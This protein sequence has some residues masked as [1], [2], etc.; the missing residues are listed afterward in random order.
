MSSLAE[1][2]SQQLAKQLEAE[3]LAAVAEMEQ[4]E[5]LEALHAAGIDPFADDAPTEAAETDDERAA[6]EADEAAAVRAAAEAEAALGIASGGPAATDHGESGH[7][8]HRERG[9]L[10]ALG[11][12]WKMSSSRSAATHSSAVATVP[13]PAR[14]A[15]A[16]ADLALALRLQAEEEEAAAR[17]ANVPAS[18]KQSLAVSAP[19]RHEGRRVYGAGDWEA[20]EADAAALAVEDATRRRAIAAAA[21]DEE[22]AEEREEFSAS[23]GTASKHDAEI[24]G[25][26]NVRQLARDFSAQAGAIEDVRGASG[27]GLRLSNRVASDLR[28]HFA[29]GTV[30]G[31]RSSG[32][33]D[34]EGRATR[35]AVL[36]EATRLILF[37][38]VTAGAMDTVSGVLRAGKEAAVLHGTGWRG[39]DDSSM[40]NGLGSEAGSVVRAELASV[41]ATTAPASVA[42]TERAEEEEEEDEADAEEEEDAAPAEGEAEAAASLFGE[43]LADL[44]S[45]AGGRG[46]DD[47][48][49]EDAAG[50]EAAPSVAAGLAAS[51]ARAALAAAPLP[52]VA[53]KV[54]RTTLNEFSQ[55][56]D[57]LS[58]DRRYR[59]ARRA[60]KQ[61]PRKLI[62]L[63]SRKEYANLHR[64][65]LAGLPCP[66]PRLH[67]HHVLVM[68][69]LGDDGWPAPQLREAG[70][71]R[72]ATWRRAYEH[73]VSIM[74]GLYHCAR[75]V[76]A[77]LSEFNLLWH[78][79]R[80]WLIDVGQSV[81]I[82]HPGAER[83]LAADCANITRFFARQGV[84]VAEPGALAELVKDDSMVSVFR[85]RRAQD[86][87]KAERRA[88]A[89]AAFVAAAADE[90]EA[91]AGGDGAAA[92]G[93]PAAGAAASDPAGEDHT[94]EPAAVGGDDD[95][96]TAALRALVEAHPWDGAAVPDTAA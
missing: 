5:A 89:V 74:H 48:D 63:W 60:K 87:A 85:H 35:D 82:S 29:K 94:S 33:V 6:R 17:G 9:P 34:A 59:H 4:R 37:R 24:T 39:A 30:K 83:F 20:A 73:T 44:T 90:E 19:R 25:R 1:I 54:F 84:A 18:G 7:T 76:H 70:T 15:L 56:F 27:K 86:R 67:R 66:R 80:V 88:A 78:R 62:R 11:A 41:G 65:Y 55:R 57:Y 64:I 2:M 26:R 95:P 38:L 72:A 40:W 75:L 81:E 36:D 96:V 91:E 43:G 23:R 61:N 42:G 49:E 3:E 92:D 13:S 53:V 50:A 77:D 32:R 68:D 10:G 79:R 69:F 21:A 12:C 58:G 31:V 47:D 46:H 16:D 93:E 71:R 28:R 51:T 22:E 45:R 8:C 52:E 14:P